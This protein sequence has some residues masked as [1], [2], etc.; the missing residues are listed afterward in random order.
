MSYGDCSAFKDV[1]R[2]QQRV[3]IGK[4]RR[5]IQFIKRITSERARE[6]RMS[7]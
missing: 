7:I 3:A 6:G 5:Q 2:N 1:E 4:C